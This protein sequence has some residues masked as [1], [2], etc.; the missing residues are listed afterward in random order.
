M[1]KNMKIKVTALLDT[2]FLIEVFSMENNKCMQWYKYF[3]KNKISMYIPT[4]VLTEFM[5]GNDNKIDKLLEENFIFL[6][7]NYDDAHS[8][9]CIINKINK[10]SSEAKSKAE[11][12]DDLKI[13]GQA[14]NKNISHIITGDNDFKKYIEKLKSSIKV[15][16]PKAD[17]YALDT[18]NTL[19]NI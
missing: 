4:I 15:I 1:T 17:V 16:N 14:E 3:L 9:A 6:P 13:L 19:L 7:Y 5:V 8:T 18:G 12:K 11:F 10:E 2:N